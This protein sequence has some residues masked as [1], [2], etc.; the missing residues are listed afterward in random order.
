SGRFSPQ[1]LRGTGRNSRRARRGGAVN[2]NRPVAR[3]RRGGSSEAGGLTTRASGRW[4]SDG[5]CDHARSALNRAQLVAAVAEREDRVGGGR[6]GG[7]GRQ[8]RHLVG[9]RRATHGVVV[10]L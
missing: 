8:V 6:G 7:E 4:S 1:S 3:S 5:S 9:D 2:R 10:V